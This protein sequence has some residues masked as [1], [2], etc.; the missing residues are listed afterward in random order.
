M[1]AAILYKFYF[2]R[3][4]T[5][6]TIEVR[7]KISSNSI[8]K[9][10]L[11]RQDLQGTELWSN[12]FSKLQ[13]FMRGTT[14]LDSSTFFSTSWIT[15]E[16]K[17]RTIYLNLVINHSWNLKC[18]IKALSLTLLLVLAFVVRVWDYEIDCPCKLRSTTGGPHIK[19]VSW[20]KDC[21]FMASEGG[22]NHHSSCVGWFSSS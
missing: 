9:I 18:I 21:S 6:E 10:D 13:T 22:H 8:F 17:Q 3:S 15:E 1:A 20:T 4:S 2:Y 11:Y 19:W 5:S 7:K 12:L 16:W 14:E